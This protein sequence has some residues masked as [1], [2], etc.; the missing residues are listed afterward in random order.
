T[1]PLHADAHHELGWAAA[2]RGDLLAAVQAWDQFL[3]LRPAA[4]NADR[5]RAAVESA[6]R[7]YNLIEAQVGV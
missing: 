4:P 5:V 3:K 6:M 1:D 2:R 7:L